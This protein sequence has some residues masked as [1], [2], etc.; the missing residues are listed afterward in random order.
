[1][2]RSLARV[3]LL[4]AIGVGWHPSAS[5]QRGRQL[6]AL[7][8]VPEHLALVPTDVAG[9]MLELAGVT[10]TDVVYDLGCGEGRIAILAAKMYGARAVGVDTD[11]NRIARATAAAEAEGVST[12]V[13]FATADRIDLSEASVVTM[14][15]PQ[16]AAWLTRNELVHPTLTRQLKAGA[17][18]VTN[19]V[20]GSMKG[21]RPARVDQFTDA[22]GSARAILYLWL[23]P[24]PS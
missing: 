3:A 15:I 13:R 5:A 9:R 16:S 6:E 11:P 10:K 17:R 7:P 14:S 2:R 19:F 18:I 4:A 23:L 1:M 12:L 24:L 21:V 22:R 8:E 20:A